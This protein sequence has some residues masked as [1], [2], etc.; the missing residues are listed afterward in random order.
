MLLSAKVLSSYCLLCL[1]LA[2]P[3]CAFA[4][5]LQSFVYPLMSP[6]VSSPYGQRIHPIR[7]FSHK[8]KGIDLAAPYGTPIRAVAQG[9]VVFADPYSR[10]GNLIVLKHSESMTTHYG[11]CAEI[12]V[13]P[14]ET[15]RAGQIIGTVGATGTATGPHLHLE[16]RINGEARNP[17][18]YLHELAAEVAG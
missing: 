13:R 7:R 2:S 12:R 1:L 16:I 6:R 15:V 10:Y 11:H 17:E 18:H 14:G 8:H 9:T 5:V 3:A 4:E